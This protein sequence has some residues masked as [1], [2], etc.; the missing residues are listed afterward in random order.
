V[1]IFFSEAQTRG[2]RQTPTS[3]LKNNIL[4]KREAKLL[5]SPGKGSQK[6][7]RPGTALPVFIENPHSFQLITSIFRL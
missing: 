4:Q 1:S 5:P 2:Q 3:F 7:E 6:E